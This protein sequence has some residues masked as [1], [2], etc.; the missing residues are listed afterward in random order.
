METRTSFIRRINENGTVPT[1]INHPIFSNKL[2]I[3]LINFSIL[4]TGGC[5]LHKL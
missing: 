5:Y 1:L 3:G 2:N 4:G